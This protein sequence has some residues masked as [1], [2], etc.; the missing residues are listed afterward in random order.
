MQ[1][2]VGGHAAGPVEL[3][4][5]EA[6]KQQPRASITRAADK[7]KGWYDK[8][9]FSSDIFG[10]EQST[11]VDKFNNGEGAFVLTGAW[12]TGSLTKLGNDAGFML[13]PPKT[14]G[15]PPRAIFSFSNSVLISSKSK[16]PDL[17]AK[18]VAWLVSPK[19]AA[20]RVKT[21]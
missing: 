19:T 14:A 18:F 2:G 21:G 12:W 17:A 5:P 20:V 15:A 16:H 7:L 3:D 10:I 13:Y 9:Y 6:G 8:G 4:V 1:A 11:A